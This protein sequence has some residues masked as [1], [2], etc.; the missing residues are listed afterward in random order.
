MSNSDIS[1]SIVVGI[2][3]GIGTGKSSVS[4]ILIDMG[5][6]VIDTDAL[7]KELMITNKKLKQKIISEF[8]KLVI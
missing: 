3:G 4:S 1:S 2:T 7:A 5:H 8:Q 6:K